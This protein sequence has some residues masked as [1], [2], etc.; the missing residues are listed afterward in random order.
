M[1]QSG[2][3]QVPNKWTILLILTVCGGAFVATTWKPAS[4]AA[5]NSGI[6]FKDTSRES[7]ITFVHSKPSFDPQ[8][9]NIMPWMSAVGASAAAADYENSG[10]ISVFLTNSAH[11]SQNALL[12]NEG[13][14]NGVPQFRDVTVES[15]LNDLNMNGSCMAAAWGDYDNDGF[16]DLFIVREGA[17]NLLFH[18]EPMLDKNGQPMKDAAGVAR[19][20]F[21]DLT[22]SA[23][24]G[25]VGYG[26]GALWFDYDRD[27]KLDLL[28]AD[29]FPSHYLDAE[30][31]ETSEPL[32]LWH[33]KSTK[34]MAESFN[35]ARN[36]GGL[37]LFHNEGNGHFREVHEQVGLT[38]TGWALSIGAGDLNNDGWPD[39]YVANDFG[40]DDLYMSVPDKSGHR[41]FARVEGGLT[42]D[43]IGRDTKKGMNVDFG[44]FD[45]SGFQSIY[46]TNIT[47]RH[48]LPEGNMLW[49]SHSD[50]SRPGGLNFTEMAEDLGINECGWGWEAKFVDVNNDGW[51]D[52][53]VLNGFISA[54]RKQNYWYELQ[55]T[56][57]DYRTILSDSKNWPPIGNKSLAG[58]QKSC[59]FVRT[60]DRFEDMAAAAGIDDEYDGRGVALADF[61]NDGAPDFFVSNQG[62]PAL[63]YINELYQRCAKAQCPHWVAFYL[64]G[65]GTT[66]NKDAI[67]ARVILE[68]NS[69]VQSAEV[70]RGNG[71]ASQSDPRMRFGL[72]QDATI[73]SV[74]ILW[75]DGKEQTLSDVKTETYH[76]ITESN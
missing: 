59:L 45:H 72:G 26:V 40:A 70:S 13:S 11:G 44:D 25:H 76:E 16:P 57:S 15:G 73:K 32:D 74:R 46:V 5:M 51:L 41:R 17:G 14:V 48:I 21:V 29:Y 64:H 67:G 47:Q 12:R 28:V 7:G 49:K 18:N 4:S 69:S 63:L 58:Y 8:L 27:G 31:H 55:N 54:D 3:W 52:L 56:V 1:S 35:D 39:I 38:D 71:F 36:G 34:I 37:L 53:F 66:S 42:A 20:R 60:G 19:R 24:V 43:K 62:Q 2:K 23:G 33:L 50:K 22:Q 30:H 68:S 75:P 10:N 61:N 65:N 9:N 6:H